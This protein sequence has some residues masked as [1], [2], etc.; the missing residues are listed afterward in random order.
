MV[1]GLGRDVDDIDVVVIAECLI[2][3]VRRGDTVGVGIRPGPI[4][5]ARR[6][7]RDAGSGNIL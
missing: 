7:R 3:V 1:E 2:G 6:N 5:V 4:D